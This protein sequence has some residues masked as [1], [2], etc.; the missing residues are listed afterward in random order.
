M[1]NEEIN[2]KSVN[3]LNLHCFALTNTDA[4]IV[5]IKLPRNIFMP[6]FVAF[7]MPPGV[8]FSNI[9]MASFS[10]NSDAKRLLL[11]AILS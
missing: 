1:G 2:F 6:H 9:S 7:F 8:A 11:A 5:K 4:L 10:F 3:C